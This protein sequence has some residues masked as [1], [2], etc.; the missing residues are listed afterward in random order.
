MKGKTYIDNLQRHKTLRNRVLRTSGHA[1][2]L[3]DG[4]I[5]QLA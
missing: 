2:Y 4:Q 3:P 1:L 5:T